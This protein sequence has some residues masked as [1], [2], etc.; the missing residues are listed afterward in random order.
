VQ[1]NAH[2]TPETIE[3]LYAMADRQDG[4]RERTLEHALAALASANLARG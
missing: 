2:T 4:L 1:F 3:A